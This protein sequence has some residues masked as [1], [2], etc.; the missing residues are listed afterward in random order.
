MVDTVNDNLRVA[1]V[2]AVIKLG[3]YTQKKRVD[4]K[5]ECQQLQL[6]P[7]EQQPPSTMLFVDQR[8]PPA[9]DDDDDDDDDAQIEDFIS[10]IVQAHHSHQPSTTDQP[11]PQV[12]VINKNSL[13]IE[14]Q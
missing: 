3:R 2:R 7:H 9:C 8:S 1:C 14:G 5:A 12:A 6:Q 11:A 13:M 4:D 10:V